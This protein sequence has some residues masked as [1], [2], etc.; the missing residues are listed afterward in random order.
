MSMITQKAYLNRFRPPFRMLSAGSYRPPIWTDILPYKWLY[1]VPI[2]SDHKLLNVCEAFCHYS[3]HVLCVAILSLLKRQWKAS[4]V[5]LNV[6]IWSCLHPSSLTFQHRLQCR[7]MHIWR[8]RFS[9]PASK[10]VAL[11][12][13]FAEPVFSTLKMEAIS[14]SETSGTT[15]RTTRRHIP[16]DYILFITT[17]LKTSNPT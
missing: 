13:W 4:T 1:L 17:A 9:K 3:S 12:R 14:S 8:D 2:L 15:Q 11:A 5:N 16:E 10:Q 7:L 6:E